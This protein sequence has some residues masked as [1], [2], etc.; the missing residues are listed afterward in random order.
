[1]SHFGL[2]PLIVLISALLTSG[3]VY[4]CN[5]QDPSLTYGEHRKVQTLSFTQQLPASRTSSHYCVV[6]TDR[7]DSFLQ[8]KARTLGQTNGR[9][10]LLPQLK[11]TFW[12]NFPQLQIDWSEI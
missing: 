11:R 2:I 7:S 10:K 9:I 3:L 4:H 8:V 12:R 5:F 6:T 1:M